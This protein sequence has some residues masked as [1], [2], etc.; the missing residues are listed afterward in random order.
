[1]NYVPSKSDNTTLSALDRP[2]ESKAL[3]IMELSRICAP[4]FSL[5][6]YQASKCIFLCYSKRPRDVFS[7]KSEDVIVRPNLNHGVFC[8]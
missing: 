4:Y 7:W 5:R 3:V 2:A 1:M 8:C 6:K